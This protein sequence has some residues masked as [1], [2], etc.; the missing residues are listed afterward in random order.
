MH[1]GVGFV[2]AEYKYNA[3][4]MDPRNP[5]TLYVAETPGLPEHR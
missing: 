2:S 3:L 5:D 4:A 1:L